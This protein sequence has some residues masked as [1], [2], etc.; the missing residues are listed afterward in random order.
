M[1]GQTTAKLR[2]L[3][4]SP[5]KVRLVIDLIRGLGVQEAIK[6]LQFSGKEAAEPVLKLLKSAMANAVHNE[7][8]KEETLVV[9]EVF[10]DGGPILHR[11]MPRAMGRATPIRK[12]TSHITIVLEG[13]VDEKATK[14]EKAGEAKKADDKKEE[15]VED[16]KEI[17]EKKVKKED[18][19]KDKK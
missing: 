2:Y 18:K 17:G 12:R 5:R 10:A 15:K 6:Q 13:E 3:R 11:W 7:H 8:L 14:T 9:K 16:K 19:T 1:N 4:K